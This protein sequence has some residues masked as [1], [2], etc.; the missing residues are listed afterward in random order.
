[1]TGAQRMRRGPAIWESRNARDVEGA[2]PYEQDCSRHQNSHLFSVEFDRTHRRAATRGPPDF[3]AEP[4]RGTGPRPTLGFEW[5]FVGVGVLDDPAECSDCAAI[6]GRIL[7]VCKSAAAAL[8]E[9]PRQRTGRAANA[10]GTGNLGIPDC[11]GR[12]GRR[13]LR[14]RL[15]QAPEF[16][17]FLRRI[18]SHPP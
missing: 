7:S 12:R 14:A 17:S 13:P 9:A 4:R 11:A 6:L 10:P 5:C 8:H 18:R 16:A 3:A 1:M 15:L 2:V